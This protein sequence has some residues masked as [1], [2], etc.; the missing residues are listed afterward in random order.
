MH[1]IQED[2]VRR[3]YQL[4]VEKTPERRAAAQVVSNNRTVQTNQQAART[5]V[6]AGEKIGRNSPCPCGSGKKYK[7]CCGQNA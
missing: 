1:L 2:T 5:P 3:M 4:R 7:N 6:R